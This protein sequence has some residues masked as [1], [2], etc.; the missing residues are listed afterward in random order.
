MKKSELK[1]SLT[2]IGILF[3]ALLLLGSC[4]KKEAPAAPTNLKAELNG[5]C[6][7]LS[8]KRVQN[9]AY[10]RIT[11]GF[12]IRDSFNCLLGETYEVFLCETTDHTYD[13]FYPFEKMNYYKIEAVNQ[14]GSSPCSEVSCDDPYYGSLP[15]CFYPNP[16]MG[17]V[18][19]MT[20]NKSHITV[21]NLFGDVFYEMELYVGAN[22]L[23]MSQLNSGI[24]LLHAYNENGETVIRFVIKGK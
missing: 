12:Q 18:S 16:T 15:I 8:W 10:Y 19:I 13:D 22:A 21:T 17:R 6:I 24:Y 4:N 7:H 3:V 23:D 9:A 14:Y 2:T 20:N 1:S 11:V 5:D